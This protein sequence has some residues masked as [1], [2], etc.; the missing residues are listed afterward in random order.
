MVGR[1]YMRE[2]IIDGIKMIDEDGTEIF[3]D[4]IK[5]LWYFDKY[6]N[7]LYRLP[8]NVLIYWRSKKTDR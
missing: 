3:F 7:L 5:W 2:Y 4:E 8:S 6:S 1:Q